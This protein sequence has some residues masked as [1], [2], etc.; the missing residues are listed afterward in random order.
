MDPIGQ[1]IFNYYFKSDR[2]KLR[3]DSNYTEDEEI[4]PVHFFREMGDLPMPEQK[5]IELCKGKVLDIGAGAGCHS[6]VLQ[7]RGLEVTAL[8]KSELASRVMTDRGVAKVVTESIF[9]FSAGPFDTVL[10]LMNGAGI[11]GTL[12][13]LKAL[14]NHLKSLISPDGQVLMD[15]TD[16]Q[17][18]FTEEDG[19]LWV[20][21][22]N[23]QY[24]G[25]MTYT[26]TYKEEITSTF[27]W[28]F[29]DFETLAAIAA[30][31]GLK[32]ELIL[33]GAENEYLARLSPV[34]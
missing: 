4:D 28:L 11:A 24:Y 33:E 31:T 5:A 9:N 25:E 32:A 16:I 34:S 23:D 1:A 15:S 13:G 27:P 14:L 18:L 3:V 17:Y 10:M 6:L 30:K 26:V 22:A 2:E 19:S 12:T 8:D 21:L 20:D 7:G 29:V